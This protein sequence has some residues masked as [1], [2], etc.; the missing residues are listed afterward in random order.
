MVGLCSRM[1]KLSLEE[2]FKRMDGVP[3]TID[4]YQD[5]SRAILGN[6]DN[7]M[8]IPEIVEEIINPNVIDVGQQNDPLCLE[9]RQRSEEFWGHVSKMWSKEK[10]REKKWKKYKRKVTAKQA[11]DN[12]NY[13]YDE[14]MER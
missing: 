7:K 10:K 13:I 5:F 3:Y 6:A 2:E 11:I 4:F 1:Q 12:F 9:N 14:I 8:C